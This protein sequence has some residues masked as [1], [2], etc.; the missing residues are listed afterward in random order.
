MNDSPRVILEMK[1]YLNIVAD[2]QQEDFHLTNKSKHY[3]AYKSML[4][5]KQLQKRCIYRFLKVQ[6][7]NAYRH[8]YV[9]NY[10]A[11]D[12]IS[13]FH[14]SDYYILFFKLS[15]Y[16]YQSPPIL[17]AAESLFSNFPLHVTCQKQHSFDQI[18]FFMYLYA[19]QDTYQVLS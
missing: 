4:I 9:H 8:E 11:S 18:F 13:L 5:Q 12:N 7:K 16:L 19:V 14:F 10:S 15:V 1:D 6:R 3:A 2:T 17:N